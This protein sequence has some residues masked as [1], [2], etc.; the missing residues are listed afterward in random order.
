MIPFMQPGPMRRRLLAT[1]G[2]GRSRRVLERPL[3]MLGTALHRGA[4]KHHFDLLSLGKKALASVWVMS[5]LAG[6]GSKA[7]LRLQMRILLP[8]LLF[9]NSEYS[10][11]ISVPDAV[12]TLLHQPDL[13][14]PTLI[15]L[16]LLAHHSCC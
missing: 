6:G 10:C 16:K 3:V 11:T 14:L 8:W 13:L 1:E 5:S 9:A 15:P 4:R 7:P 12:R 2:E